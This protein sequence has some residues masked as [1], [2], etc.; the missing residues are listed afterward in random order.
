VLGLQEDMLLLSV[1]NVVLVVTIHL[2]TGH[3][4]ERKKLFGPLPDSSVSDL[5]SCVADVT[6]VVSFELDAGAKKSIF[7]FVN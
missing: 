6:A 7:K 4:I 1:Q 5:Q 3:H 2:W